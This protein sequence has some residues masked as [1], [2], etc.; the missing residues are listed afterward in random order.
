MVLEIFGTV[1]NAGTDETGTTVS[2]RTITA[3]GLVAGQAA[4]GDEIA[5]AE[6]DATTGEDARTDDGT[7][8]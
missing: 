6:D 4:T 3:V 2:V 7:I 8:G 1:L 5:P